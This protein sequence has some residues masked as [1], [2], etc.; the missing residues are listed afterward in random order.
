MLEDSRIKFLSPDASVRR[1]AVERLWDCWERIKTV[2][3]PDNKRLSVT[4][5][6]DKAAVET[7]IRQM[8]EEESRKLTDIGNSFHIRHTEVTQTRISDSDHLDYLFHRLFAMI[9]LLLKKR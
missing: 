1:E 2:E 5:L 8:L 4:L 9:Q 7:D 3:K 6:L